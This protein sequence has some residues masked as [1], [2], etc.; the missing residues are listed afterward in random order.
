MTMVDPRMQTD[1]IDPPYAE[2]PTLL[3]FVKREVWDHLWPWR[4]GV[5]APHKMLRAAGVSLAIAVTVVWVLAGLGELRAVAVI[6]WWFGW[7]IYEVL[8]RL[9]AKRYVKDG[10][11]WGRRYRVAS[12]MDMI[13]YVSFKNLLVG[14]TLFLVLKSLGLLVI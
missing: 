4:P 3:G 7:S 11:W 10:P 2:Q 6:G 9:R 8:V 12:V 5:G 14:A 1:A 13:C